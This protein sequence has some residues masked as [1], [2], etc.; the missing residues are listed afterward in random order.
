MH[1]KL[2][3]VIFNGAI[4]RG[5]VGSREFKGVVELPK[6]KILEI[7]QAHKFATLVCTDAATLFMAVAVKEFADNVQRWI[8]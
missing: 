6:N 2:V 3:I 5:A 1:G 8:F 7:K 4:L